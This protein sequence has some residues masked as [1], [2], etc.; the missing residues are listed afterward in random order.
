MEDKLMK[1]YGPLM[2]GEVLYSALGFEHI[3]AFRQAFN[4]GKLPVSVFSLENK[5]GKYALTED[6][7]RWLIERKHFAQN[8]NKKEG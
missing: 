7:A 5:R 4:R 3:A 8:G 2:F 1:L 6:V